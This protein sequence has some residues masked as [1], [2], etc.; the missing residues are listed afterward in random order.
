MCIDRFDLAGYRELGG[1]GVT[2]VIT[3]PWLLQG[4][5]FDADVER[6]KDAVRTFGAEVIAKF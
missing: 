1:I 3:V 5:G 6:K 2:D 4:V